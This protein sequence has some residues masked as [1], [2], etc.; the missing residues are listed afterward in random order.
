MSPGA[1]G[2]GGYIDRMDSSSI[3]TLD[4]LEYR[5][6]CRCDL[7]VA[8]CKCR[9]KWPDGG[10]KGDGVEKLRESLVSLRTRSGVCG[11]RLGVDAQLV[12]REFEKCAVSDGNCRLI[13]SRVTPLSLLLL[14]SDITQPLLS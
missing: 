10:V 6:C 14:S 13:V 2:I 8:V 11:E 5:K 12:G 9:S 7:C 1:S 4:W 3:F